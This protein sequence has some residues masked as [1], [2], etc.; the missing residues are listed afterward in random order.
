MLSCEMSFGLVTAID[1]RNVR[2]NVSCQEPSQKLSTSVGLIGC[3]ILWVNSELTN[4][5]EHTPRS[6]C[7]VTEQ[8]RRRMDRQDDSAFGVDTTVC[9]VARPRRAAFY[10]PG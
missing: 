6:Q 3:Q 7:L 8:C 1:N 4:M 9:L 2:L 10:C 5:L